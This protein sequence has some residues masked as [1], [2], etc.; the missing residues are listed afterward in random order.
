MYHLGI[1]DEHCIFSD[2]WL[3]TPR[4]LRINKNLLCTIVASLPSLVRLCIPQLYILIQTMEQF[5]YSKSGQIRLQNMHDMALTK[6][7]CVAI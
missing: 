2:E 7:L 3:C 6:M 1:V 5:V 4:K